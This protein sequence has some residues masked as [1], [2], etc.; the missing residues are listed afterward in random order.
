MIKRLGMVLSLTLL[1]TGCAGQQKQRIADRSQ[2]TAAQTSISAIGVPSTLGAFRTSVNAELAHAAANDAD[3]D[4]RIN[5]KQATLTNSSTVAKITESGGAPLWN[6]GAWPGTGSTSDAA[7]DATAWLAG[8][9]VSP[10]QKQVRNLWESLP[11]LSFPA[12]FTVN[13]GTIGI[14][15]NTFQPYSTSLL[16]AA[17]ISGVSKYFGTNSGG[18]VGIYDLPSGGSSTIAGISDWPSGLT[19]TE[20]GYVDGATSNLQAQIN[21][22][23]VGSLPSV[24]SDP[25]T[26]S[27]GYSWYNSTDHTLNMAQS[28]GATKFSGTFTAWDTTPSA[29]DFTDLTNQTAD[30]LEKC[31]SAITLAGTN[32]TAPLSVSGDTGCG[33]KIGSSTSAVTS[34][35]IGPGASIKA[36]VNASSSA[37]TTTNC[38]PT[39]GTVAATSAFSVTTIASSHTVRDS[40]TPYTAGVSYRTSLGI[41]ANTL[42]ALTKVTIGYASNYTMRQLGFYPYKIGSPTGNVTA[43][44]YGDNGSGTA[45]NLSSLLGTSTTSIAGTSLVTTEGTESKWDFSGVSLT[46]GSIYWVGLHISSYID[47]SNRVVIQK[48]DSDTGG[49]IQP[50]TATPTLGTQDATGKSLAVNIYD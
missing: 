27:V 23:S 44:V 20:L 13:A 32:Y 15:A 4:N 35:D 6:G 33:V 48:K 49:R 2:D 29:F 37:S 26:P 34:G 5:A 24:T 12:P 14:A 8:V 41:D 11:T 50:M 1:L 30:G 10:S 9:T 40:I 16:T 36:C 22:L 47:A 18:A 38:T 45:P 7:Y 31:S 21:A 3:L 25:S 46:T 17:G 43:V 39:I 42:Y 19:A 28:T